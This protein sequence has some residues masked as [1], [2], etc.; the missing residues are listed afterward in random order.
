[1]KAVRE[2]LG[3]MP[4]YYPDLI[5][6]EKIGTFMPMW[7]AL[8]DPRGFKGP[9]GL[10]TAERRSPCYNYSWSHGDCWNGPYGALDAFWLLISPRRLSGTQRL[11]RGSR[12]FLED[13]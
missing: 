1:M 8:F 12:G 5:P 2:L 6:V 4:F 11:S 3:F 10:R 7:D 9:F 13:R